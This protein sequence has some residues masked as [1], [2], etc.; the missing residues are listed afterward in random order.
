MKALAE[1][2]KNFSVA[3]TERKATLFSEDWKDRRISI[4]IEEAKSTL[5]SRLELFLHAH[6]HGDDLGIEAQG[7]AAG[8]WSALRTAGERRTCTTW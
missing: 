7:R 5:L 6:S 8:R 4:D 1:Y 2:Q 3:R